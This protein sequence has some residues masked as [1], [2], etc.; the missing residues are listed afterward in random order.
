M[1]WINELKSKIRILDVVSRYVKID[2]FTGSKAFIKCPFHADDTPSCHINEN[3]MFY[4]FGCHA[5]GDA[6]TF[7][8]KIENI[9]FMEAVEKLASFYDFQIPQSKSVIMNSYFDVFN[10][11]L[12]F[13][14][15]SME[16]N[17]IE[18]LTKRG[19]S[20]KTIE[21]FKIGYL[22][23]LYLMQAFFNKND[24]KKDDLQ[25]VGLSENILYVFQNRI[26]FPIFYYGQCIAI[27]GRYI[28]E[29]KNQPKYINISETQYFKKKKTLYYHPS[30]ERGS[31]HKEIYLVEGYL[32]VC[33][34]YQ[35][36]IYSAASMGTACSSFHLEIL[37]KYTNKIIVMLDGDI[38]GQQASDKLAI[39]ALSC[40][41]PGKTID[42]ASLP[43]NIDPTDYINQGLNISE[44]PRISLASKIWKQF[45]PKSQITSE[46]KVAEYKK[47]LSL[48]NSIQDYDLRKLYREEWMCM[49]RKKH[50]TS[51]SQIYYQPNENKQMFVLL[52]MLCHYPQIIER[53]Y[54]YINYLNLNDDLNK[55]KEEILESYHNNLPIPDHFLTKFNM[56][57]LEI[58]APF[59]SKHTSI[60]ELTN[61]WFEVFDFF[62]KS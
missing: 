43:Q 13:G 32:D 44:V 38:A 41:K 34:M 28:N 33:F 23:S 49:W 47:V 29:I 25:E 36:G 48:A 39:E 35:N 55:F 46:H 31:L 9:S 58:Y 7:V 12:A 61:I 22:P 52:A 6:I 53:A 21:S 54:E 19:L 17:S 3:N 37:W 30:L 45:N 26:I 8:Q 27:S 15:D 2:K 57:T 1:N 16:S 24:I 11:I 4:C 20:K 10:K 56:T 14:I 62:I 5:G 60:D 42:F 40:V 50:D 51:V 59:M 18:Y